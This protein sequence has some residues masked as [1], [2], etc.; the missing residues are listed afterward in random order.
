MIQID[1]QHREG[2]RGPLECG[3]FAGQEPI[4]R[5]PVVD[6]RQRVRLRGLQRLPVQKGIAQGVDQAREHVLELAELPIAELAAAQEAQFAHLLPLDR[7][8]VGAA[9][10]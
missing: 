3:Q 2:L 7:E 8:V 5:G 4:Q 6:S 9:V 10:P 1:D